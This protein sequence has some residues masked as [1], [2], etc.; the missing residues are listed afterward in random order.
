[1]PGLF[2]L[3]LITAGFD[4]STV[5]RVE[6]VLHW[7]STYRKQLQI[8]V[9][10]RAR[11]LPG[12]ELF[13]AASQLRRL[14]RDTEVALFVNDRIDVALA[15]DA[16]GAQLP[17]AGLPSAVARRLVPAHFLLGASAHTPTDAARAA[18]AGADFVVFAPIFDPLSKPRQRP[19]H[20]LSVLRQVV[21]SVQI[22]V[23][24]LGGISASNV[25]DCMA[26]GARIASLGLV[27]GQIDPQPGLERL[28]AAMIAGRAKVL[29]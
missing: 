4:S 29:G 13:Q 17:A 10:L 26:T 28:F 24:A 14:T 20:G 15:V 12:A 6:S 22:P 21:D 27:L 25:A 16:D 18:Q 1:M 19:A 11:N 7:A 23:F 3:Y 9:Q 2:D 5:A 8:A